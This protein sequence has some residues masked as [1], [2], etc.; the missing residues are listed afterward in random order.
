MVWLALGPNA[1]R[2]MELHCFRTFP[3]V[4]YKLW[5]IGNPNTSSYLAHSSLLRHLPRGD[6][7]AHPNPPGR[8]TSEINTTKPLTETC[9][10]Q[11]SYTVYYIYI[12]IY[13]YIH[14]D[15]IS[16]CI[17][18]YIYINL[19]IYIYIYIS[20]R[21]FLRPRSH[22]A[23]AWRLQSG[24]CLASALRPQIQSDF[25]SSSAFSFRVAF[26]HVVVLV[27]VRAGV[28]VGYCVFLNY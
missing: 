17:C 10:L 11:A 13:T 2:H 21:I 9:L 18:I 4:Q 23:F 20:H 7:R 19:H 28:I 15:N 25:E 1:L 16:L 8:T 5:C 12:Y 14:R 22:R 6:C 27:L 3:S 26:D 24:L